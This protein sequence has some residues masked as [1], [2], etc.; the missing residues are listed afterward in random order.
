M[1]EQP[2]TSRSVEEGEQ[3]AH[4][5]LTRR[6][7]LRASG[8]TIAVVGAGVGGAACDTDAPVWQEQALSGPVVRPSDGVAADAPRDA[9]QFLNPAQARIVDAIVARLIPGDDEDPGAREA[10]AVFYIDHLLATHA[11]YPDKTYTKAPFPETYSGAAPPDEEGVVWVPKEEIE[12]YGWQSSLV[13]R[14]IYQMGLARLDALAQERFGRDFADL[15]GA[16][17]D[18]LL[19]AVEDAEDDDVNEVFGDVSAG[20]FFAL[21]RRHTLEGFLADPV[22][23]GNRDMAGWRLIGFPGERRSYSPQDMHNER[24]AREVEPQSLVGMPAFN[25]HAE[26]DHAGTLI[27]VRKRHPNGPID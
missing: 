1:P 7:F 8:T 14:E 19:A 25:A 20:D 22:Y 21:V 27:T 4:S 3:E 10:G 12:R 26:P 11:G 17:Q 18:E 2:P 24:F 13:P 6:R 23:G 5:R 16:P 9:L 15:D